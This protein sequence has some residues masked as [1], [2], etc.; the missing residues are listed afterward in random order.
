MLSALE[1]TQVEHAAQMRKIDALEGALAQA[2]RRAGAEEVAALAEARRNAANAALVAA[3]S[4]VKRAQR[5]QK[6]ARDAFEALAEID[7]N[8]VHV[9]QLL[10]DAGLRGARFESIV[11]RLTRLDDYDAQIGS[12]LEEL[13]LRSRLNFPTPSNAFTTP[14]CGAAVEVNVDHLRVVLEGLF[15]EGIQ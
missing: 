3:T 5:F 12:M 7:A 1:Q 9:A 14:E 15:A 4:N 6:L 2:G 11:N 10:R 8:N 13:D